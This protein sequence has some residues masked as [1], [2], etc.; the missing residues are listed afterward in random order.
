MSKGAPWKN[1]NELSKFRNSSKWKIC[2]HLE[3]NLNYLAKRSRRR[4]VK[5]LAKMGHEIV[6]ILSRNRKFQTQK[7]PLIR[8]LKSEVPLTPFELD[9]IKR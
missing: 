7:I 4:L 2:Q 3:D 6:Q 8:H 9:V 5:V 1:Q